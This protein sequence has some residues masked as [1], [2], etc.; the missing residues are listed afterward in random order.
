MTKQGL[1]I[2]SR[3]YR[4]TRN[5]STMQHV[6]QLRSSLCHAF[7]PEVAPVRPRAG[8]S[9]VVVVSKLHAGHLRLALLQISASGQSLQF[10]TWCA[11]QP[12]PGTNRSED[13]RKQ[14]PNLVPTC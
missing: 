3:S 12:T 13:S 10:A 14:Y 4:Y 2:P 11:G 1:Q 7:S 8:L 9:V 6:P 5:G